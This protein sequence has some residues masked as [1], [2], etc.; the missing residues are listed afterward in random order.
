MCWVNQPNSALNLRSGLYDSLC[1]VLYVRTIRMM[2]VGISNV[3][4]IHR[5]KIAAINICKKLPAVM[6]EFLLVVH[7]HF[8]MSCNV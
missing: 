1:R 2:P 7:Q 4:D 8:V 5:K 3:A 6:I